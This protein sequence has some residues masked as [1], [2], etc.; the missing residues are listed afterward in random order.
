MHLNT[1]ELNRTTIPSFIRT[2]KHDTL[3][4]L[5]GHIV[6]FPAG[7]GRL[8]N[9]IVEGSVHLPYDVLSLYF[10]PNNILRQK[11][12]KAEIN[13]FYHGN[14]RNHILRI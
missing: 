11:F 8:G 5:F 14:R 12:K 7:Y 13:T 6:F 1:N 2:W 3:A 10:I 9:A 4:S